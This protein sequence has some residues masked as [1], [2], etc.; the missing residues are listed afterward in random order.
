[1]PARSSATRAIACSR[2]NLAATEL[3]R[4]LP[5]RYTLRTAWGGDARAARTSRKDFFEPRRG[6]GAMSEL[7]QADRDVVSVL[8]PNRG[9]SAYLAAFGILALGACILFAVRDVDSAAALAGVCILVLVLARRPELNPGRVTWYER[10]DS[11]PTE[12]RKDP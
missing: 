2:A 11:T 1:M 9:R 7:L 8:R 10:R 12:P 5:A 3:P 4:V 6:A